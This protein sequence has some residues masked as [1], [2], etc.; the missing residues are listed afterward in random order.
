MPASATQGGHNNIRMEP[1]TCGLW[2]NYLKPNIV[3]VLTWNSNIMHCTRAVIDDAWEI[4]CRIMLYTSTIATLR[5]V[6]VVVKQLLIWF[7]HFIT[8]KVLHCYFDIRL[9][10]EGFSDVLCHL[11]YTRLKNTCFGH[12]EMCKNTKELV[13]KLVITRSRLQH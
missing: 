5:T 12:F 7:I 10:N 9:R 6:E 11:W 1:V 8:I 3:T 4:S 2:K 13:G